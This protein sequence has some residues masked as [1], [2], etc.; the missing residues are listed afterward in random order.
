MDVFHTPET[1]RGL[2][3]VF[4]EST[5][6][7]AWQQWIKP[8]GFDF[9]TIIAVNGASGGGNGF[10]RGAGSP[11]GGGGGGASGGMARLMLPLAFLPDVIYI[12]VAPSVGANAAGGQT[13]VSC[14]P[15]TTAANQI[16]RGGNAAATAGGNGTTGAAGTAATAGTVATTTQCPLVALGVFN[17]VAGQ[18]GAAGGAHTGTVGGNVTFSPVIPFAGGNGGGGI[19]TT[20]DFAGGRTTGAGIW[21]TS[22]ATTAA[23]EAGRAGY[24]FGKLMSGSGQYPLSSYGGNGGHTNNSGTGGGGG[25]GGIGAGGGGGGAGVTGGA[26]GRGG[27]GLVVIVVS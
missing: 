25:N 24:N 17:A 20:P 10:S 18:N 23:G 5:G 8:P 6:G 19:A 9:A 4:R 15:D 27:A 26:G 12:Q 14:Y 21:P 11:G 7:N 3:F 1:Q 16:L 2:T 22:V 13:Y